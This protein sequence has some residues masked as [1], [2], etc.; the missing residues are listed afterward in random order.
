[1]EQWRIKECNLQ[2]ETHA[3][4]MP[5]PDT[6]KAQALENIFIFA[7]EPCIAQ[8]KAWRPSMPATMPP[9]H[10]ATMPPCHHATKLTC[11]RGP[12]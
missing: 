7:N 5:Q 6:A 8:R 4:G 1:M 11:I 9:C 2:Q 3:Q 12:C 10:H